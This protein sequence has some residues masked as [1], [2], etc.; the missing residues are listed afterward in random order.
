MCTGIIFQS[1]LRDLV[2]AAIN[3]SEQI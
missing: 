1:R 2:M 3:A